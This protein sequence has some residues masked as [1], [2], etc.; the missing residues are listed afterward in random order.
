MPAPVLSIILPMLDEA[1]VID[2][3]LGVLHAQ[4]LETGCTFEVVCVDDG[5]TDD[6]GD[7]LAERAVRDDWLVPVTFSRNFGKEA[8]VMAGLEIA[9]GRAVVILDADLQHPPE[10]VPKMVALWQEGFDVVDA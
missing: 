6:T 5:S 2:Q 7:L 4:L 8:A 9:R 10:L 3:T 1:E